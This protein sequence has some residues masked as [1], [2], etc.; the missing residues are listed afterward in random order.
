M[1]CI[2][3]LRYGFFLKVSDR[4]FCFLYCKTKL[5]FSQPSFLFLKEICFISFVLAV[6]FRY[7]F[8]ILG[9]GTPWFADKVTFKDK[10][11]TFY[12]GKTET[13]QAEVT[14]FRVNSFIRFRWLDDED[15]KAYFELKM[16]YNELTSDY[17]LEVID[18]ADPD[19]VEDT[20]ELWDSEIEKLKR[21][22]GL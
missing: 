15:P 9:L 16:V 5:K 14:N 13:R 22:S 17:M 10:V 7:I 18:W 21:V 4:L 19:E 1:S 6:L 8:H 2:N 11:F 3:P 20:K 12:W